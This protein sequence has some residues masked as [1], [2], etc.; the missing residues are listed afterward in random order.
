MC[1]NRYRF[2]EASQM[3]LTIGV[4]TWNRCKLLRQTLEQMTH[5]VIP[6]EV[7]WELLV[8]NNN[9]TDDT[10][11][12]IAAFER[13]LPIRR[14]FQPTPGKSH[15]LNLAV[16]EA[17]GD[18][19]LWTD[20]D[21]LVDQ[22]WLAAY[23]RAFQ[24]WPGA[25]FFG[26]PVRPWFATTPPRWLEQAWPKIATAYATRD[27]GTE[28]F[29]LDGGNRVPYGVNWAIRL[30]EQRDYKYN[31]QLGRRPGSLLGGEES[32]LIEALLAN[33]CQG[34]WVP[35]A[36]VQHYIPPER[37]TIRYLEGYYLGQGQYV[38]G[39]EP[40]WNGPT[41]F[42]RPRWLWRHLIVA[43]LKYRF[44]RLISPPE[45]WIRQL[46]DARVSLGRFVTMK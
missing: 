39:K 40:A 5:L 4:C 38:A 21:A 3:R 29:L 46:I 6:A 41:I 35:D 33:G 24:R 42:G 12:E 19:I 7:D 1:L 36:I 8:V 20:D 31:P 13:R 18:Y 25:A 37:M 2:K 44:H 26:G 27:L 17:R 15:A 34:W 9:S 32:E 43:E 16:S 23:V 11:R 28:P 30:R 14:L 22:D 10:D 45:V